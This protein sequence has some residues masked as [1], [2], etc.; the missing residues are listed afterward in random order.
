MMNIKIGARH[1]RYVSRNGTGAGQGQRLA[2]K[3]PGRPALE[4]TRPSGRP[5]NG[6]PLFWRESP[7]PPGSAVGETFLTPT[8]GKKKNIGSKKIY[9]PFISRISRASVNEVSAPRPAPPDPPPP[10]LT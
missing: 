8:T 5:T 3:D 1:N 10:G 7:P 2:N 9:L 6:A 4:G